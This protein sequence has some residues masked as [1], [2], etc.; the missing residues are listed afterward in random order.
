MLTNTALTALKNCIKDNIAGLG[1][2][3]IIGSGIIRQGINKTCSTVNH[4][5]LSVSQLSHA[6]R[7]LIQ[8]RKLRMACGHDIG[9]GFSLEINR[10]IPVDGHV[11]DKQECVHKLCVM[12]SQGRC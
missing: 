10:L 7:G 3:Q 1:V 5:F 8:C 6:V 2:F 11:F 4:A 12:L 9:T